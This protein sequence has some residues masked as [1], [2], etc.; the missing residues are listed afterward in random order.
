M[1]AAGEILKGIFKGMIVRLSAD[2]L[3]ETTKARRQWYM[4]CLVLKENNFP[5]RILFQEKLFKMKAK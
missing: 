4:M 5:L 2:F 1:K 3:R